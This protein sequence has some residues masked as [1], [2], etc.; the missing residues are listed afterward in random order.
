M[1]AET[2]ML[3]GGVTAFTITLYW[4][5]GRDLSERH[6]LGWMSIATLLLFCGLFPHVLIELANTLHLS[7]PAAVLFLALSVIYLF[8]FSVSVAITRL[9]R[10]CMRLLQCVALLECR[11]RELESER[12]T[13]APP[14]AEPTGVLTPP[15]GRLDSGRAS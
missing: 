15:D 11:I 9:H 4:V 3:L 13:V 8:A 14:T 7:Y 10:R 5:R 2:L 12:R 1:N 6:A